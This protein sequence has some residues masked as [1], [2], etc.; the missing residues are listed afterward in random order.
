[1]TTFEPN[2]AFILASKLLF[3]GNKVVGLAALLRLTS[4]VAPPASKDGLEGLLV[5][6]RQSAAFFLKHL[7]TQKSRNS[8]CNPCFKPPL[9]HCHQLL[10]FPY[11][12]EVLH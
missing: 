9:T 7:H 1:M 4:Q 5:R 10:L 12:E 8:P 3:V 2:K 6:L 11:R